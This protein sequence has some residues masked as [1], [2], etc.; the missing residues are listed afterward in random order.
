MTGSRAT[1]A[2]FALAALLCA[3]TCAAAASVSLQERLAAC[4]GCHGATGT[5]TLPG[6][7]S[8]AGQPKLFLETQLILFREA[9]R[10]SPQMQPFA[11]DLSDADVAAIAAHYAAKPIEPRTG[12]SDAALLKRGRELA[13]KLNCGACHMPDFSGREQMAR[14]AGQREDYLSEAMRA[15][16]DNRRTADTTMTAV[17]YGVSDADIAALAHYLARER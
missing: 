5:S 1:S 12:T 9:V 4:A 11:K 14:L 15:Y 8:I 2:A 17:L 16:R 6:V 10:L 7:P 3:G 13:Q